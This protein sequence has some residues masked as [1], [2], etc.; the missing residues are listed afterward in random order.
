M[1]RQ[2]WG[3]SWNI[4]G[5]NHIW[6]V[7]CIIWS[8][9]LENMLQNSKTSRNLG[10]VWFYVFFRDLTR[11]PP[12][13]RRTL[14]SMPEGI[15]Q[16]LIELH[17]CSYLLKKSAQKLAHKNF[18]QKYKAKTNINVHP[19]K[20]LENCLAKLKLSRVWVLV[21]LLL[22][23]TGIWSSDNLMSRWQEILQRTFANRQQA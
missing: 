13:D 5:C 8:R 3:H 19:W 7:I 12:K 20:T 17:P 16:K 15:K 1:K 4:Y 2:G 22:I 10:N 9:I 14:K 21:P 23:V 11:N 6:F 18:P